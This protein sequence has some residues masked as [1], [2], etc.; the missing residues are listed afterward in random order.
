VAK[1]NVS[2]DC[3]NAPKKEL[4]RDFT[5]AFTTDSPD[6]ILENIAHDV[7]WVIV[8]DKAIEGKEQMAK[9]LPEM[10]DG[11]MVELN[12]DS[13]ITHG[14]EGAVSGNMKFKEGKTFGFCDLYKFASHSGDAKIKTITSFIIETP[15][16]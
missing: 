6:F 2:T 3:G 14:D 4:L 13:I 15:T 16:T 5:V 8:G 10:L 12:I 7:H 11:S 9:E 1:V